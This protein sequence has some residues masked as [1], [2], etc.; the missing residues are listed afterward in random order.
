MSL[1]VGIK[2]TVRHSA[3]KIEKKYVLV[4]DEGAGGK[5]RL[6]FTLPFVPSKLS[7]EPLETNSKEYH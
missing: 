3:V 6:S 5:V 7:V 2:I 4:Q 1:S